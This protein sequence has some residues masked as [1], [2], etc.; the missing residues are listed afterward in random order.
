[1]TYDPAAMGVAPSLLAQQRR[2]AA[3]AAAAAAPVAGTG[4]HSLDLIF[5][6]DEATLGTASDPAMPAHVGPIS[7]WAC[8]VWEKWMPIDALHRLAAHARRRLS[9]ARNPWSVVTGPGAGYV[10]TASRLGWVIHDGVSITTDMGTSINL[11]RDPPI[12]VQREAARAVHRW[13][14]RRIEA[15]FPHLY[16]DGRGG[17]ADLLPV[18]RLLRSRVR[19][20]TWFPEARAGLRSTL[21]GRQWPQARLYKAALACHNRCCY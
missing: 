20:H 5:A 11:L 13:R 16:S 6:L 12:T 9:R 2:A 10:A 17:G 8:A 18:A 19:T 3:A 4:G 14:W 1:M 21:V 7:Q 15:A